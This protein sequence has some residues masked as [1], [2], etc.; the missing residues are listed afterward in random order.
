MKP[1]EMH[2]KEELIYNTIKWQLYKKKTNLVVICFNCY[3]LMFS[4]KK[5]IH[6]VIEIIFTI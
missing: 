4:L 2:C 6:N 1:N 3:F 5:K